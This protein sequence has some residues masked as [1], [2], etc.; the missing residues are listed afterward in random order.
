[1][2]P[3][4]LV[5]PLLFAILF[6]LPTAETQPVQPTSHLKQ[7]CV[8]IQTVDIQQNHTRS[9]PR[10]DSI[11]LSCIMIQATTAYVRTGN[12]SITENTV[13]CSSKVA[14]S[15]SF[16]APQILS[17]KGA[18]HFCVQGRS[19]NQYASS[20]CAFSK[21]EGNK[22]FISAAVPEQQVN[23]VKH[24]PFLATTVNY[25][26]GNLL[27]MFAY[28]AATAFSRSVTDPGELRR[29]IFTGT[30]FYPSCTLYPSNRPS[31]SPCTS[32]NL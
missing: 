13:S 30:G 14:Y 18:T 23:T 19:S 22:V 8:S 15:Y 11:I 29:R 17:T 27:P 10:E 28:R 12:Y 31:N 24:L 1:M 21:A 9:D 7:P 20:F 5:L 2:N 25:N 6:T 3:S 4:H 26:F 16:L 32:I